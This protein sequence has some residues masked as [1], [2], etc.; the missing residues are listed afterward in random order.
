MD[1]ISREAITAIIFGDEDPSIRHEFVGHYSDEIE[2]FVSLMTKAFECRSR[3]DKLLTKNQKGEEAYISTLLYTALHSHVVSLKLFISGLLVPAGNTQRYVLECI[4]MALLLSRPSI[5]VADKYMA[6]KYST[7][8][9]V[10]D[11]V[12]NHGALK[13]NRDVLKKFE[14]SIK[15]YDKFSHPTRLSL[16]GVAPFSSNG[17]QIIFGGAYDPGKDFVYKE[18]LKFKNG[19]AGIFPNL[20]Q[21]IEQNYGTEA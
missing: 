17:S 4:A 12:R 21:G 20:I 16:I 5:G 14:S 8:K 6:D 18:E 10:R 2:E 13:L 11:L 1:E 15:H 19:L 9:A 3:L 7:T